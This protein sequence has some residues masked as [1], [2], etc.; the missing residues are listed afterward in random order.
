MTVLRCQP[1]LPPAAPARFG[2][3]AALIPV[4]S[5][6]ARLALLAAALFAPAARAAAAEPLSFYVNY[7]ARVPVAPLLAHP[8]SIVHPD[9]ELDLAAAHKAG[10]RVLAYLSFGEIA[11]DAP[12]RPEALRRNLPLA[13]RN[14]LWNSDLLDLADS[15]W[16]DFLVGEL[17]AAAARRGFD[18]FFLDTLDSVDLVAPAD[19]ARTAAL[20]A[21]LVAAVKR[22]RAAFPQH[23]IVVNRGFFAFAE[24]RDT[25]DGVLVES[26]Y[27][28]HDFA[29][30]AHRAV[31]AADT[32]HLLDAL[33]PV[34]AAGRAVYILDYTDPADPARADAAVARIRAHGFHAFV[35]T[36]TLDGRS[37][38]PLRPVRR[39]ICAFFGNLS[40]EQLEQ[41][42]WPIDSF[43]SRNLQTPLEWL[44]YEVDYFGI[45]NA[46]DFPAL[47]DEYRA[48]VIPRFWQI[49]PGVEA[50]LIDWLLQQRAAGRKIVLFG[51]PFRDPDQRLRFLRAFGLEG[52]GLPISDARRVEF[53]HREDSVF[54]F[55]IKAPRVAA[56]HRDLRA[57]AGARRLLTARVHPAAGAPVELDAA[58]VAD[59]GGAVFDPYLMFRRPDQREFW[60][61]N[62]FAFLP[63][64]LGDFG[65]PAPDTTTRDGLRLFM[66]HIDGDGFSNFSRVEAGQRSAEIVRDRLLKKYP[67][68]VTVSVIEAE[69]RGLMRLQPAEESPALEAIARSIFALPHIEAASH[70]FSHPFYW[71]ADDRTAGFYDNRKLDLKTSYPELNYER[72][73]VASVAYVDEK[74]AAP[75]RP[76]RVFLWTGNCRPPPEALALVRRLGLENVNGG[77]TII[78]RR[79]ASLTAV[80]PRT[81][82][83]ADELQIFAPN[84]NENVYTNNWQGPLFGTFIHVLETFELTET[85]RR[86]KPA[87]L[88]YHFYSADY[89]SSFRALETVNEWALRQPLQAIPLSTYARIARDSRQTRLFAAGPDRWIAVNR[90]DLRTFR[91]PPAVA[92]RIDLAASSGVTGWNVTRDQ[93]YVHTDG[94]PVVVLALAPEPRPHPRL[95]SSSAP[96]EFHTRT[97]THVEFSVRDFRPVTVTLAGLPPSRPLAVTVDGS[98]RTLSSDPDGRAV[99]ELPLSARAVVAL[100]PP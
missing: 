93:A 59:W 57:P 17:A 36:P 80:A 52:T 63:L 9:A 55:E 16:A 75:G 4:L 43:V 10:N 65:A 60:N 11:A 53:V 78:S 46:G 74:L 38:A 56:L 6:L 8:L 18:G 81:M 1:S 90:G 79:H 27:E 82:P 97:S 91:L 77:D 34:T 29:T 70:S 5:L 66:S 86:L 14:A 7:S 94:S 92:A 98:A 22:L 26:L 33:R 21:G 54:D 100:S 95:E 24:L 83:W 71:I 28:T 40:E 41:I 76:V 88:Y 87:N 89:D 19:P 23:R 61:L 47:D 44:G 58:F 12:Y 85:P 15:R 2:P 39:R 32:A 99:L 31:P 50:S 48:I 42:K 84:Q 51:L 68:P 30:K 69:L 35:S 25:V 49:Q 13:G 37:L 72:E 67:F 3:A 64:V 96:I 73:I 45:E 62:P 20:R